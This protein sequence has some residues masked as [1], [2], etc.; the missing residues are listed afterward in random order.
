MCRSI[1][2]QRWPP[3]TR[4]V[5]NNQ[6]HLDV[7]GVRRREDFAERGWLEPVLRYGPVWSAHGAAERQMRKLGPGHFRDRLTHVDGVKSSS[8]LCGQRF[9]RESCLQQQED[10]DRNLF[11][12]IRIPFSGHA[13]TNRLVIHT[14]W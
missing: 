7:V 13:H 8:P 4:V 12:L 9:R 2:R 1:P 11:H 6:N 5:A 10:N 14:R 3:W